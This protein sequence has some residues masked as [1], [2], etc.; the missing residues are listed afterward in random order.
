MLKAPPQRFRPRLVAAATP[1][2]AAELSHPAHCLV[3]RRG[4]LRWGWTLM[5]GTIQCLPFVEFQQHA[6]WHFRHRPGQHRGIKNPPGNDTIQCQ[7]ALQALAACQLAFFNTTPTFQNAMPH[8][9]LP[10]IMPPKVEA[11]TRC[12]FHPKNG[13]ATGSLW[14]CPSWWSC[15]SL[16]PTSRAGTLLYP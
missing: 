1:N 10:D 5:D 13:Y 3:Q 14:R 16:P 6:A 8:F 11:F 15:S 7:A 12:T 2:K 4:L 9:H